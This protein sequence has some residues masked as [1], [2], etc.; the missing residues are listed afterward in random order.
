[1]VKNFSKSGDVPFS[2]VNQF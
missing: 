1:M 2:F